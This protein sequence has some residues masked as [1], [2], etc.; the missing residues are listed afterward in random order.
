M[1]VCLIMLENVKE[2]H[3]VAREKENSPAEANVEP[4]SPILANY[5]L[6]SL[7]TIKSV[8]RYIADRETDTG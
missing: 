5:F 2:K 1:C 6:I 3:V 4:V 8:E 7:F